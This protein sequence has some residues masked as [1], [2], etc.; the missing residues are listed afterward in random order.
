MKKVS[1]LNAGSV[2][3]FLSLFLIL[4]CK[5]EAQLFDPQCI[6]GELVNGIYILESMPTKA[7]FRVDIGESATFYSSRTLGWTNITKQGELEF[8]GDFVGLVW[9]E[10]EKSGSSKRTNLPVYVAHNRTLAREVVRN[11]REHQGKS[12][13]FLLRHASAN[14]GE[15]IFDSESIDWWKSCDPNLARQLDEYGFSQAK[16]IGTGIKALGINLKR[17]ITSEFCRTKQTV[18]L[19]ELPITI[20]QN[21]V[22]NLELENNLN[23]NE[24]PSIWPDVESLLKTTDLSNEVL[25]VVTHCNLFDRNP[26]IDQ[27]GWSRLPGDGFLMGKNANGNVDFIGPLPSFLWNAF[28]HMDLQ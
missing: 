14:Q 6:T 12:L 2:I 5:E 19:M 27:I 17:G 28:L 21:S 1:R 16:R 15:D 26:Y 23:P 3:I 8:E 10:Y 7:K 9:V 13:I 18:S 25:M 4:G 22:L 11:L 20:T 24:V